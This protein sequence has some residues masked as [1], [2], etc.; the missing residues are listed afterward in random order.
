MTCGPR[1][2]SDAKSYVNG[3]SRPQCASASGA[4]AISSDVT[5]IVNAAS[6][7]YLLLIVHPLV[8]T[9]TLTRNEMRGVYGIYTTGAL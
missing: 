9:L 2:G 8:P 5:S 3:L 6:N 1:A 4:N 7:L